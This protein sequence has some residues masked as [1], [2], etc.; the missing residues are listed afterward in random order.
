MALQNGRTHKLEIVIIKSVKINLLSKKIFSFALMLLVE[1][2]I[3]GDVP[4]AQELWL[5]WRN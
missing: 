1:E 2:R 3:V 5:S 4:N